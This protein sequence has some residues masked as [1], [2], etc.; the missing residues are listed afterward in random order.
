MS[1]LSHQSKTSIPFQFNVIVEMVKNIPNY[2][3]LGEAVR[4]LII[5]YNEEVSRSSI[6]NN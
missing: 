6:T 1:Q 4:K 5:E 2:M 3:D